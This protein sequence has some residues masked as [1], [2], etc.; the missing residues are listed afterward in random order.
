M[1]L[2]EIIIKKIIKEY[3]IYF[4]FN[5]VLSEYFYLIDGCS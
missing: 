4:V 2:Y 3:K 1:K 5:K